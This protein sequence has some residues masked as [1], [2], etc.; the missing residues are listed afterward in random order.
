MINIIGYFGLIFNLL[1]MTMKNIIHLRLL[2]LCGNLIYIIY[3][4]LLNSMPCLIGC[5]IA[6]IIQG[7]H[8]Y[9]LIWINKISQ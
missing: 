8:I 3:G 4:F 5:T 9:K 1:S 6:V 2:A 7:Y